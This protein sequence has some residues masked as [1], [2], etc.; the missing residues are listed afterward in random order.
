ME[1]DFRVKDYSFSGFIGGRF[2]FFSRYS[3][4]K[5]EKYIRLS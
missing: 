2:Y 4:F 1:V 3:L 5:I